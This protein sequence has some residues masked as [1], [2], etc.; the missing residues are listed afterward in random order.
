[1]STGPTA[2]TE[3]RS[4]KEGAVNNEEIIDAVGCPFCGAKARDHCRKVEG[5]IKWGHAP[6]PHKPR[7]IAAYNAKREETT[8]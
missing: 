8:P 5:G 4:T 2:S 6:R 7:V 1:M 3:P